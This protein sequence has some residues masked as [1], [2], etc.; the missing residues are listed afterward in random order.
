MATELVP[1]AARE[2]VTEY[3]PSVSITPEQAR[4]NF[5]RLQ[6]VVKE[7]MVENVDYGVIPGTPK[8]SL[9]KPGAEHL[10]QFFGFGHKVLRIA[11]TEEWE[12][13][14]FYYA[15][16]VSV[17]K[18]RPMPDGSVYEQLISECE[19][20]A[21]SKEKRYRN[22]DVFT[23]VNTLQKMAIKRAMVGATLQATGT[24]GMFTQDVEDMD[25]QSEEPRPANGA[26]AAKPA[27]P[28]A[29]TVTFGKHK[30][31][32]LA[33]V[34][35]EEPTYIK[36]LAEKSTSPAIQKAA[37][38]LLAAPSQPQA[39]AQ[40]SAPAP[41]PA[42]AQSPAQPAQAMPQGPSAKQLARL[43]AIAHEGNVPKEVIQARLQRLYGIDSL[44]VLTR[45][46]YDEVCE[47]LENGGFDEDEAEDVPPEAYES[48]QQA[49]FGDVAGPQW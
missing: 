17:F 35:A 32:S 21:N 46:Q 25:L 42:P 5:Q 26:A 16:R 31:K 27:G 6:A 39:P 40:A 28:G 1:M 43:M 20:S 49:T 3:I 8:P 24:S 14:F 47:W 37:Q 12:K 18:A 45:E 15:Y 38:A 41:A 48:E 7:I 10:M 34:Q 22:Q 9:L 23:I 11:A 44:K 13:G 33:Q 29:V 4:D 19:G 30:G 36:W 2:A